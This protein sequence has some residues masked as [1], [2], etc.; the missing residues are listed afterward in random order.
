MQLH[1]RIHWYLLKPLIQSYFRL[2][3]WGCENIPQT[4]PVLLAANHS[5]YLDPPLIALAIPRQ[6]TFLAKEEL[7]RIPLFGRYIRWVGTHPVS[8]GQGDVKA[9]RSALKLLGENKA[10]LVFP[11]GTRSFDGEL[12]PLENGVSWLSLKTG[13]PLIP[14]YVA[15]QIRRCR[16]KRF[17]PDRH[18]L[19]S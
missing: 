2:Q 3:T 12:Q 16:E 5:S 11:E 9:M 19:Q 8:R 4:G 15:G 13:A 18:V 10:L 1:Y 7:F 14:V 6:I 17:S